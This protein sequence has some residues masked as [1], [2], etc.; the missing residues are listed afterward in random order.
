VLD[1]IKTWV[2]ARLARAAIRAQADPSR[3]AELRDAPLPDAWGVLVARELRPFSRLSAAQQARLL[4]DV[5]VFAGEKEFVGIGGFTIDERAR[6]LISA[7]AALLVLG[8][9]IACLDHVSRVEVCAAAV[10][11]PDGSRRA[12]QYRHGNPGGV[13][14]GVVELCWDEVVHGLTHD[15]GRNVVL[16]ELAH[17][18]DHGDGLL[19]ALADHPRYTAWQTALRSLPLARSVHGDLHITTVVADVEGPELFAVATELFFERPE[20]LRRI[21]AE[22]FDTMLALYQLDPRTFA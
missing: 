4:D 5:K 8:L 14:L 6:V 1:R 12:G 13:P 11:E 19:D 2:A 7:S 16:H 9:D 20:R 18:F 3:R 17:A 21:D 22:L 15:D 10:A